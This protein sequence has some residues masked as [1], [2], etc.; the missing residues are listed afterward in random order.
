MYQSLSLHRL[1]PLYQPAGT[2]TSVG[3]CKVTTLCNLNVILPRQPRRIG[4]VAY[5]PYILPISRVCHLRYPV[6]SSNPNSASEQ[7]APCATTI[8]RYPE[9]WLFPEH[10]CTAIA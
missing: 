6:N 5:I 7:L 8:Q 1:R 9:Q 4:V 2:R 3:K 10:N